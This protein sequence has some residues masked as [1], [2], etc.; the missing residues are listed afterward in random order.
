ME[1]VQIGPWIVKY[2]AE[3]TRRRHAH[4]E[5]GGPER[6]GCEPCLNFTAAR[7]NVYPD[8]VRKIFAQLGIDYTKEAEVAYTCRIRPGWHSYLGWLH[9][10]GKV[11]E[12]LEETVGSIPVNERFSW[13]FRNERHLAHEVFSGQPLVQIDFTAEV[14]WVLEV[15]EPE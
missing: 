12:V 8:K 10:V 2:D 6:C 5:T 11:E 13:S 3:A 15:Q 14:P 1:T 9:F 7:E 4:I